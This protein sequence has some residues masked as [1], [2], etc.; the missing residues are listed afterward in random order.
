MDA[1]VCQIVRPGHPIAATAMTTSATPRSGARRTQPPSSGN[2]LVPNPPWIATAQAANALRPTTKI[3]SHVRAGSQASGLRTAR[4][5][6][7]N[8]ASAA[9]V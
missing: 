8:P 1:R 9:I 5:R 6:T 4:L 2:R 7:A 3:R